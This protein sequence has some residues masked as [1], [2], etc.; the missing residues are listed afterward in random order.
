[1]SKDAELI[2]FIW[3]DYLTIVVSFEVSESYLKVNCYL[4]S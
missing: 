3:V 2:S 1:M 4:A